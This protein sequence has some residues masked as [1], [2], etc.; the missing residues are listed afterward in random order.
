MKCAPATIVHGLSDALSA[1]RLGEAVTLVSAP[2]AALHG[3]C[4]WW[5]ALIDTARAAHPDVECTDILDCADASGLALAALRLGVVRLV[6]WPDAPG[7]AAIVALAEAAGGFV[8]AESP[9]KTVPHRG[10]GGGTNGD[11]A[12]SPG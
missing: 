2:G 11:K 12:P 1:L 3:G 5:K 4:G 9:A 8:L 6:L 10:P 7:R